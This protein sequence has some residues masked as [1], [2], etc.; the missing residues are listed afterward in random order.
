MTNGPSDTDPTSVLAAHW[1]ESER[2]LYPV[3]TTNTEAYESAVRIVRAVADTLADVST[4]EGLVQRWEQRSAIVDEV[5]G[6]TGERVAY[7][8]GTSVVAGA[9]FAMRRRELLAEIAEQR[10]RKRIAEAE[11]AG[12]SWA[13]IHETGSLESGLVDPYVCVELHLASGLAVVSSVERDASTMTPRYVVQVLN[14][15]EGTGQPS[16]VNAAS[17]GDM[18]TDDQALFEANREA[19]RRRVADMRLAAI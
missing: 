5:V 17:F 14:M 16:G 10:Q 1:G 9:G 7:V 18:E 2:R 3:A 15:D 11:R 4:L 6:V 8:L 13:T 19:M 12:Q